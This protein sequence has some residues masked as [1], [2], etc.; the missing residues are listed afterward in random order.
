MN[1]L[2]IKE[3]TEKRNGGLKKLAADINMSEA[4]LHRCINA[5]KIQATDLENIARIYNVPV[6]YFFDEVDTPDLASELDKCRKEID[7]L[8]GIINLEK[9]ATSGVF[10]ALPLD[11]DEFLDLRDMK[12]KVI[13]ILSK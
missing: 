12:D 1:L 2:K 9:K 10:L 7:R 11:D 8:N 6:G 5:N 3:L 4:N 13:R